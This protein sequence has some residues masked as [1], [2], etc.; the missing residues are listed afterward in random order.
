MKIASFDI[1]NTADYW[2]KWLEHEDTSGLNENFDK[3]GFDSMYFTDNMGT[4]FLGF[5]IYLILI[6]LLP[7]LQ[8]LSVRFERLTGT[9]ESWRKSIFYNYI[10]TMIIES[11][12]ILSLCSLVSLNFIVFN[13]YGNIVDSCICLFFSAVVFLFPP[14]VTWFTAKN[15]EV[16][17]HYKEYYESYFEDYE[18]AT[19]PA[20]LIHV[21]WFMVRRLLM[22]VICVFT[23][24]LFFV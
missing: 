11:Y 24:K 5:I 12:S 1:I 16:I 23:P 20:V 3:L 4:M 18:L 19:G 21:N 10:S 17:D 7:L 6:I 15:W 14:L 13:S 22:A 8:C 9:Y 2:D